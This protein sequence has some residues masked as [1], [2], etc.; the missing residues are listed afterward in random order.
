[1]NTERFLEEDFGSFVEELLSLQRF[2]DSKEIGIAKLAQDMGYKHLTPKQK[3]VF[4]K[5]ID[6]YLI[7]ECS[8]CGEDIPWSEMSAAEDN[9]QLCSWCQQLTSHDN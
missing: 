8:R 7:E 3:F 6:P 5:S 4:E 2:N 9:G 1:M